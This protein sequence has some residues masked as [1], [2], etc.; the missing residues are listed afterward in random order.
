V[1]QTKAQLL[2]GKAANI[3]FSAGTAALPAITFTGDLNTG[4]YSP[5]ADTIAFA[6]GGV[7]AA[8]IDSSG[9]LLVGTSTSNTGY[10]LQVEGT[11]FLDSS[12]SIR[13]NEVGAFPGALLFAKSKGPTLNSFTSV[14]SGDEL[15]L[16]TF[17]GAD[18]TS[19]I[20]AAQ[21]K[22]AVDGTP[23][24]N[25]MPGRLVFSTTADGASTLTEQLR[26][27]S[28]RY[29]RLASGTGG[30]QFN[31]DTAAANA[32]DDYEEGTFTPT[33]EGTTL[34]G[35][36]SYTRAAFYTKIGNRVFFHIRISWSG[37]TGT[38][39]MIVA[40]LPFTSNSTANN[41]AAVTVGWI[42]ALTLTASNVLACWISANTSQITINQYPAGGGSVTAV[43]MDT[44]AGLILSGYY[45]V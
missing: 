27:T 31:G 41:Q 20:P 9:R 26:I 1:S 13:R 32:L 3:E 23:G 17:A 5:A 30:I 35:T 15:G 22:A 18:G 33:I 12:I 7:E 4:I 16:I 6:E 29:V 25:D 34:A 38:G 14:V 42:D 43:A 8:R 10:R 24:A 40:G 21:I 36:A 2:E 44:A 39:N 37:H 19:N 11:G 28:D 45:I